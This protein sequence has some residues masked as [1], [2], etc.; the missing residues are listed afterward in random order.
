MNT[1]VDIKEFEKK[2]ALIIPAY[3]PD[4][5]LPALIKKVRESY[6]GIIIVVNDGS[7]SEYD[8]Y[9][10]EVISQGCDVLSHYRNM[11][12]GRALKNAFNYCLTNYPEIIGCVTADSDGQHTP[13]DIFRCMKELYDNGNSLI[14]GC[15][16]FSGD[17]VPVNSKIGNNFMRFTSGFLCGIKV[18]DTQ[19]GLRGIPKA[20]MADLLSVK[21]ERF[22]FETWMLVEAKDK[23]PFKEITIDTVYDS[24][25]E[26]KTHFNAIKDSWKIVKILLGVFVKF[27]FA[28][29]SSSIID[30]ILFTLICPLIEPYSALYY[31]TVA[32]VIARV[33]SASYNYIVNYKIVFKSEKDHKKSTVKYLSLAVIIMCLSA[34]FITISS[35]AFPFINKTVMKAIVDCILFL[36]SYAVQRRFIF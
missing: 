11:G 24:V 18:S 30:L 26:H 29:L 23:Y 14:L 17:N 22:E 31:V 32:T 7:G 27:L 4:G 5:E 9:Y 16:D 25:D 33:I 20:F 36:L 34:L 21:G 6:Q 12:K 1:S 8:T 15:R 19:T 3:E 2:I 35:R 13:E 10:N 28:S